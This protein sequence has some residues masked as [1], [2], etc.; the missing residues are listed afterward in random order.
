[1][2][3][4]IITSRGYVRFLLVMT[5]SV[6]FLAVSGDF[7]TAEEATEARQIRRIAV[8]PFFKGKQPEK[9]ETIM[10]CPVGR[11][12]TED[13]AVIPGAENTMTA[14][15]Q[16]TM[17]DRYGD[18]VV[19]QEKIA[20]AFDQLALDRMVGKA[21]EQTPL[22]LAMRL[23]R[24]VGAGYVVAGNVWRFTQRS[25]TALSAGIPA[26]VA[27]HIHLIDVDRGARIWKGSFDRTQQPLSDNLLNVGDFIQQDG[28]WLTAEDLA[29]LGIKE[30][31][32]DFPVSR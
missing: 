25:G 32:K 21:D 17:A 28:Q 9:V 26:S 2:R 31:L 24:Q 14:L 19:P 30:A 23:G 27:F 6:C 5:L 29:R 10:I 20:A 13:E 3:Q 12:C 15:L 1:M 4:K 22:D 11:L 16:Q 18:R 7:A 8:M